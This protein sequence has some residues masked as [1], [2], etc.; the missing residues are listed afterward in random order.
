MNT[1]SS[2]ENYDNEMGSLET[3]HSSCQISIVVRIG[4]FEFCCFRVTLAMLVRIA[5]AKL[6]L[7]DIYLR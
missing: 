7:R 4:I 1:Y 6:G 5:I 2:T 3:F